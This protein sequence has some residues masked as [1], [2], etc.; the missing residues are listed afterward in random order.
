LDDRGSIR[1]ERRT[2]I[3]EALIPIRYR[4]ADLVGAVFLD[5]VQPSNSNLALIEKFPAERA[6]LVIDDHA[7]VSVYEEFGNVAFIQPSTIGPNE[8]GDVGRFSVDRDLPRKNQCWA[9]TFARIGKRSAIL[10]PSP[11]GQVSG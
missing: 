7:G 5:V 8:L 11:P 1:T 2:L 10:P 3:V 9:P 6:M 4:S